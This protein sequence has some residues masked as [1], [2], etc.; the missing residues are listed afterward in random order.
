[1][2]FILHSDID[3]GSIRANLGRPEY[4]YYFVL[5]AFLPALERLGTVEL[6]R[7]PLSE[8]DPIFD[9]CRDRGE[10][11]VHLSFSPPNKTPLGLRCP[12]IVLFAWEYSNIPYESWDEDPR[13]DWRV[14]LGKL[15]RAITLSGHTAR[16]VKAAM[17]EDFPVRA[18]AA[19]VWDRFAKLRAAGVPTPIIAG[20]VLRI[21][22]IV[23]DSSM[24]NLSVD[25]LVPPLRPKERTKETEASSEGISS[26]RHADA[27]PVTDRALPVADADGPAGE[28]SGP[29]TVPPEPA[30]QPPRSL[31]Y[32]LGIGKRHLI[33]WYRETL[34]DH[35][36]RPLSQAV[37]WSGRVGE[38]SMRAV[39]K[40]LD[41]AQ[42]ARLKLDG[43]VYTSVLGPTDG[44]KNWFDMVTGFCFAFRDTPDATLVL[45][46]IHHEV[47]DYRDTLILLLSQLAPFRCRVIAVHAYLE[48][49]AY[50]RL[51][52][53]T[54]YYVNTSLGEG[55]CLPL[56]EFMASGRPA[57]APRHTAMED[58]VDEGGAFIVDSSLQYSVWPHDPRWMF[59][60]ER[61]RLDWESLVAAYRESYRIAK[62]APERYAAMGQHAAKR[63]H[64]LASISVVTEQLRS[65][66]Q[67]EPI[68]AEPSD[69]ASL[70]PLVAVESA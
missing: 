66:F 30:A 43:V 59:R 62:T 67:P 48:D 55:L 5:R 21:R 63:I 10:T 68:A 12:S 34:R 57:I 51:I 13:N 53:G 47:G 25:L 40:R 9:R 37:S 15:G 24:L 64:D 33:E 2:H 50:A 49:K 35:L 58:Y 26:E 69:R 44:R 46:M 39:L 22:G 61:Y 52:R 4:S 17:G 36:P 14:P 42:V 3:Q 56:M 29:A 20:A 31:R 65:F 7:D 70:P 18:I 28:G 60:S 41:P 11:C 16:T 45:K 6:V 1:M 38:A 54:T 27:T 32:R 19:P 23:F 8:I